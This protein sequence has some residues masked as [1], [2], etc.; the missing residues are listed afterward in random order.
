MMA[1]FSEDIQF[2]SFEHHEYVRDNAEPIVRNNA[3]FVSNDASMIIINEMPELTPRYDSVKEH[4][5]VVDASLT[6]E[7]VTYKQQVELYERRAKFEL[8]VREQKIDDQLRIVITD[9]NIKEENFKKELHFVKMQFQST[10]NHNKSMICKKRITPT[11]LTKGER[12]FEQTKECYLTEVIP[13][14]KMLNEHF[15]GIQKALTKEIKEMKAIFDE[16]EAEVDQNAVNRKCVE[17]ERKNLLINNDT[18]IANCFSKEV[19]YIATNSE[20]N[21]SRFYKMHDAD[22]IVQARCLELKTEPSKL[23]YKIQK[24][25]H[26]VMVKHF[27][28]LEVQHLNLQL[29]Y[30]HLKESLGN[31]N[32]L[33][34]QD[35]FI[36]PKVLAPGMYAIDVEPIPSHCRNNREVHLEY[37]K[38]LKESVATIREIVEEAKV[39][40]PLDSLLASACLYT[41]RS[42][43]LVEYVVGT[44]PKDY[45]KRDKK[46][47]PGKSNTGPAPVFLTPGQ[48]SS[49]I[50]PSLVPAAPYVPPTNKEL[51]ILFKPMFNEY[52]EPPRVERPVSPALA[53]P[54]LINSASTPL[55]TFIDQDAHSLSHSPSSLTLQSPCL[56]QGIAAESTL[57]DENP[58]APVD[59]D[60]FINIYA[61]KPTFE[62]YHPGMLVQQ[63]PPMSLKHFIILKNRA[64]ISRLIMSLATYFNRYPPKNNL[65]LMSCGTVGG[66]G[67]S[68]RGGI[69]FEESFAP[70]ARIE[71][72]RIFISN[73]ASKNMTIYQMDVK[74][75]F[76]NGEL[77]EEVY[78]PRACN[79]VHHSRSKHIDIR[80]HF[81][82]E[83][84]ENNMVEL[85]FVMTDYQLTDIFTK[86]LPRERF[87]FLLPRL[88][89]M[90][91]MSNPASDVPTKQALAKQTPAIVPPTRTEDHDVE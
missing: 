31:N 64:R 40:R 65:Q 17:I 18:L 54:V 70:V 13:F 2:T 8:T 66:Q 83:Q 77:K 6:V 63:N 85:F 87:E 82:Q 75:A 29:K 59:N 14:F 47:A 39:E 42:Q 5:K 62:A 7:L 46:Q 90:A 30:Q 89:T 79:N 88:D 44:F 50:I 19:F 86:A 56:H 41:K 55:S 60:P 36:T 35:D 69:N 71:A 22:T 21:V 34:A 80:H 1:N 32:S 61:L 43:E 51:E 24:D 76:L 72:I 16:L 33:P 23:K 12:G 74:T 10:I 81:I 9:R 67:I 3:S 38:H 25:D 27:F 45:N 73:T 15:E 37:L 28:N 84:V 4:T 57:M 53:V 20:L 52:L 26:D 48:T 91:D 78:V 11:G 58:F 68:I 49:M